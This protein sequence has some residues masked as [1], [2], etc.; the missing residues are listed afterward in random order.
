MQ[1]IIWRELRLHYT[2]VYWLISN[3]IPPLFYMFFF[4]LLFSTA[5]QNVT[6]HGKVFSYLHF[7][8][9][10]LIVMQSFFVMS[11]TLSIVNLDR[12]TRVLE[13]IHMTSTKFHEYFTGRIISIQMLALLKKSL[14]WLVA[15]LFLNF[16][17][18]GIFDIFL[19]LIVFLVSNMFWFCIGVGFGIV[20]KT[21][22]IRDIV[23]QLLTL[24]LTFLSN[25][26]YPVYNSAGIL[27]FM[28]AVNPLTH[29]TNIIR[30]ALLGC[31]NGIS[32]ASII[33]LLGYLIVA[34]AVTLFIIMKYSNRMY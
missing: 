28:I 24:P 19:A 1:A 6:F 31:S 27:K 13:M 7:F 34:A 15:V 10:G 32:Y 3:F 22:E 18:A 23:L 11:Y 14:L 5:F 26:Y 8:I 16:A 4:G 2:K 33:V 12:R 17:V 20:I 21:E 9:P 29:A 25:I 30:P